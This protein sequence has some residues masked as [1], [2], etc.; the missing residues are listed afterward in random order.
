MGEH[1]F[2][3]VTHDRF[4]LNVQVAYHIIAAP[5]AD[6]LDDVVIDSGTEERHSTCV[7]DGKGLDVL[8]R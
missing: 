8:G 2:G 6:Y 7:V 3:E 1:E 4:S 5:E